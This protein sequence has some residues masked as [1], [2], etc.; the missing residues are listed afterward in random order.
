M[1]TQVLNLLHN[2]RA[3][4]P[5]AAWIGHL[6][7]PVAMVYVEDGSAWIIV[8]KKTYEAET[9]NLIKACGVAELLLER[10]N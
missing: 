4:H 10:E 7:K 6:E 9:D 1:K 8:G 2:W 3:A 5:K